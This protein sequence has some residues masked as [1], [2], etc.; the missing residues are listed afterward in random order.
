M[1]NGAQLKSCV[2]QARAQNPNLSEHAAKET[3]KAQM[4]NGTPQ[5]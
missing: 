2:S 3:C 4:K 1:S 5:Q